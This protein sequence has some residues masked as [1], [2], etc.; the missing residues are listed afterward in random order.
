MADA[1]LIY[2]DMV[3]FDDLPRKHGDFDDSLVNN[4]NFPQ[5][6]TTRENT[7]GIEGVVVWE[8]GG[9]GKSFGL[10]ASNGLRMIRPIGYRPLQRHTVP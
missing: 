3:Q 2:V 5:P 8:R 1:S 10:E 6:S 7:V 9:G 4:F